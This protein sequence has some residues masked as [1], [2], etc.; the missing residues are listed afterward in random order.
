ME[1]ITAEERVVISKLHLGGLG[2]YV[3]AHVPQASGGCHPFEF[4]RAALPGEN[5]E[6]AKKRVIPDVLAHIQSETGRSCACDK[7]QP[8]VST[9][10]YGARRVW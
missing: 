7:E 8:F 1:N 9:R 3:I 4:L 2:F 6:D 5:L 10:I